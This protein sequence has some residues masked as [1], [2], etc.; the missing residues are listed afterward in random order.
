MIDKD[1]QRN[2]NASELIPLHRKQ[3]SSCQTDDQI[4]AHVSRVKQRQQTPEKE[5]E[6]EY[7]AKRKHFQLSATTTNVLTWIIRII[8]LVLQLDLC[9]K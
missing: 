1:Q 7:S 3:N 6:Q 4:D 9:L 8:I 2:M 5:R